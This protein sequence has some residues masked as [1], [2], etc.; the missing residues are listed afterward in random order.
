M[1][2]LAGSCITK[3]MKSEGIQIFC[4]GLLSTYISV[5]LIL[6]HYQILIKSKFIVTCEPFILVKAILNNSLWPQIYF[7]W[8]FRKILAISIDDEALFHLSFL[9]RKK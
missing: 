5:P 9:Q 2:L 8:F 1:M 7:Y 4:S 3:H 6:Y